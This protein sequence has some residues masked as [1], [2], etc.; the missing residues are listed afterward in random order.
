MDRGSDFE[1]DDELEQDDTEIIDIDAQERQ[2][3]KYVIIQEKESQIQALRDNLE[4]DKFVI[5][6]LGARKQSTMS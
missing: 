1:H 6:Y 4:R 3:V 2:N 5:A